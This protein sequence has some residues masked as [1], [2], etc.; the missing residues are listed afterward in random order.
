MATPTPDPVAGTRFGRLTIKDGIAVRKGRDKYFAVVCDCGKEKLPSKGNLVSGR[1]ISCGCYISELSKKIHTTH[2]K[3]KDPIHAIWN[4]MKQRCLVPT[5]KQYS[6][7]GGRGIK[8]CD[9][10]LTFENFY[11]DMGDPPFKGASLE[12]RD[13]N[14]N[15]CKDNVY[16]LPRYKQNDNRRN[17]VRFIF[18]GESLSIR[19]IARR[20]GM[21]QYTLAS[22]IY[23]QGL[24]MEEAVTRPILT[25]S[26]A[27]ALA[28]PK[29][30]AE[31]S[32]YQGRIE[33]HKLY[34]GATPTHNTFTIINNIEIPPTA[35][36]I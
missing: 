33:G 27:A 25:P 14:G 1:I 21:N 32:S 29:G 10:W 20:V 24:T 17:S 13:S 9:E 19:E 5:N 15:Y 3:S 30:T 35:E 28:G 31:E 18:K 8:V 2:G 36:T 34:G 4:M 12:R 16:W 7:Y 22:R 23:S 6:D 11:R 26:E